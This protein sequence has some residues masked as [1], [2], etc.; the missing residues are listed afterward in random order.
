MRWCRGRSVQLVPSAEKSAAVCFY[1][2]DVTAPVTLK[3]AQ[4]R[5]P[6]TSGCHQHTTD[7]NAS[8]SLCAFGTSEQKQRLIFLTLMEF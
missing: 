3:A 7:A 6:G 5:V 4:L 2:C 1:V 8:H